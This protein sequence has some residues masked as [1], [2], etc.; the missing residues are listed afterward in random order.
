MLGFDDRAFLSVVRSLGR[1]GIGVHVGWCQPRTCALRSR[2]IHVMHD[3][4]GPDQPHWHTRLVELLSR[5]SFDLVI[6][7][8]DQEL[9]PLQENRHIF[10]SQVGVWLLNDR[11]FRAG[12]NKIEAG[13][14]ARSLGI[15]AP[16]EETLSSADQSDA[17]LAKFRFPIV[18]KPASSFS[19]DDLQNKRMVRR[20]STKDAFL[21][22]LAEALTVGEVLVQENFI[23]RGVGVEFLANQG[24]ALYTFQ[25][26]RV[27]EPL[28]G[29]GSS[30]RRSVERDPELLEATR[31]L[32]KALD[33]TGV[34]MVEFRVDPE[35]RRWVFLELNPRFWGSLPLAI[36][37]GADFPRFLYELLVE[38]RRDFPQDYRVSLYA[39]HVANDIGWLSSNLRADK[40][41]QTLAIKP[42]SAV[43]SE[44]LNLL[45]LR[46]RW[47]TLTLDDPVPGLYDLWNIA[48]RGWR[49]LA[50]RVRSAGAPAIFMR[51]LRRRNARAGFRRSAR[52]LFVCRG[53]ICRSPFAE[54]YAV[55]NLGLGRSF[56][57]C[58]HIRRE[59]RQTPRPGIEAASRFEVDLT[60]HRSRVLN[61]ELTRWADTIFV[62]DESDLEAVTSQYP[63]ARRKLHYLGAMWR[64]GSHLIPDPFGGTATE[65]MVVYRQIAENLDRL[66]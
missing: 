41:D 3:I 64:D 45:K 30:Y 27:H 35:S 57:S 34:G 33:Y 21:T 32:V 17:V 25:H 38:G 2:Y 65:F 62:F 61:E 16:M 51:Y 47:D 63:T 23:G 8:H 43:L 49:R 42:L 58:G 5:E 20:V 6:P 66:A 7:C 52:V 48:G 1:A 37:A 26:E 15:P 24:E 55:K 14:L 29:G 60:A 53:N 31:R 18:L 59:G 9:I 44:L 22:Y 12:T 11:A 4:P 36:A 56:S 28:L 13:R 19:I 46:E 40:T 39:R 50:R 10:D 54:L